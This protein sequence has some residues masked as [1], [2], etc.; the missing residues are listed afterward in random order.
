FSAFSYAR[1]FEE[2]N[3]YGNTCPKYIAMLSDENKKKKLDKLFADRS[4]QVINT[5]VGK[6]APQF[7]GEDSLGRSFRLSDYKGKVVL[8]DLWASWCEPCRQ[9]TPYFKKIVDKYK[10]DTEIVFISMA[11]QDKNKNWK[12]ALKQ[13]NPSWLQLFDTTA[14]VLKEY[15]AN[16]IPKF[17]IIGKSGNIVSFDAPEP[18]TGADLTNMLDAELSK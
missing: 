4:A 6:A 5:K 3:L 12:A 8:L 16:S 1:S 2:L 9:E 18:H 10:N 11:V 17:V 15:V 13:D 7:V 14:A